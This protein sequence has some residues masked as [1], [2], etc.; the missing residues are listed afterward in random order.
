MVAAYLTLDPLLARFNLDGFIDVAVEA[1]ALASL[2]AFALWF[3]VLAPL[4]KDA[5]RE[6][7]ATLQR[8]R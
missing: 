6:R 1:I 4:R 7:A 5:Q 2:T 3:V 8:E